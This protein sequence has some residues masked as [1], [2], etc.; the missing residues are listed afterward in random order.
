MLMHIEAGKAL[1]DNLL[2]I[3]NLKMKIVLPST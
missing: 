3:K 2:K 1:G